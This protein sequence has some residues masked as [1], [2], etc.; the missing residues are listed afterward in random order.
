M[1]V[2][3]AI[4]AIFLL[5]VLIILCSCGAM[6]SLMPSAVTYKVNALVNG[7]SIEK[8]SLISSEDT[9]QPC[10]EESVSNDPDITALMVYL[11]NSDGKTT[12]EVFIYTLE[13]GEKP[14]KESPDLEEQEKEQY[15]SPDEASIKNENE[16]S[17]ENENTSEVSFENENKDEVLAMSEN[18]DEVLVEN[19][20]E[21]TI[22]GEGSNTIL[23]NGASTVTE[24]KAPSQ[25]TYYYKDGN[26]IIIPV[27]DFDTLPS[28]P[29]SKMSKAVPIGRY[30][31]VFQVMSE[32]TSLYKTEKIFYYLGEA[33][34][35]LKGINVYLPGIAEDA[36]LVP[37]NTVIMLEA[38]L[39]FDARLK[40][41]FI[42]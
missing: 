5:A 13:K 10:F 36:Q 12:G 11:R 2:R 32:K 26:D 16:V 29:L 35:S 23:N 4:G 19:E 31:L 25:Q 27:Q 39:N 9:I 34:F 33:D 14:D 20:N 15:D 28:L 42:W 38:K 8:Y 24:K 17:A 3:K 6:D 7:V 40:P 21:I 41:Y 37:L 30:T 22:E 1:Y 18:E